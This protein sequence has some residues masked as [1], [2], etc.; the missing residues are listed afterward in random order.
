MTQFSKGLSDLPLTEHGAIPFDLFVGKRARFA[1]NQNYSG[2]S[3]GMGESGTKRQESALAHS[4]K[5]GSL[6]S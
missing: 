6:Y 3:I 4:N 2:D 5:D 1:V